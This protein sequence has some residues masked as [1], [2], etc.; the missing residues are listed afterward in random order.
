MVAMLVYTPSAANEGGPFH[1][2]LGFLKVGTIHILSM[3]QG[4]GRRQASHWNRLHSHLSS[5]IQDSSHLGD[6][7][8]LQMAP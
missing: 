3:M 1:T 2:W 4:V 7:E 6:K 8:R 5:K